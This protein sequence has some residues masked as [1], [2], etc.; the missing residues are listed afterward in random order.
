MDSYKDYLT[1]GYYYKTKRHSSF[2]YLKLSISNFKLLINSIS[3]LNYTFKIKYFFLFF[4]LI[5][6]KKLFLNNDGSFILFL[7]DKLNDHIFYT[8]VIPSSNHKKDLILICGSKKK[9]IVKISRESKFNNLIKYEYINTKILNIYKN[10]FYSPVIVHKGY[11][12]NKFFFIVNYIDSSY[13]NRS[14]I[15]SN[16]QNSVMINSSLYNSKKLKYH[17]FIKNLINDLTNSPFKNLKKDFQRIIDFNKYNYLVVENHGDFISEN[18]V[19]YKEKIILLDYESII[20]K[21]IEG[22]DIIHFYFHLFYFKFKLPFRLS[23]YL[24]QYKLHHKFYD[25]I[26]IYFLYRIVSR[27]KEGYKVN[28]ELIFLKYLLN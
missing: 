24:I 27:F 2:F 7:A 18:I 5:F 19:I 13:A 14:S 28:K 17:P 23:L 22:L 9:Y 11:F 3:L 8:S 26:I 4:G 16:Y 1:K 25:V 15:E 6:K 20:K 21:G 12:K 10:F